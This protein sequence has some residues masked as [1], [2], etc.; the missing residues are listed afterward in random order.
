MMSRCCFVEGAFIPYI[1]NL[2]HPTPL[3]TYRE[4][5]SR[6]ICSKFRPLA[7]IYQALLWNEC[8]TVS[9]YSVWDDSHCEAVVKTFCRQKRIPREFGYICTVKQIDRL[10][11][12]SCKISVDHI[13]RLRGER[14][15]E[16]VSLTR[17]NYFYS[18]CWSSEPSGVLLGN[19]RIR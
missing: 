11:K 14:F 15:A 12:T 19:G 17:M 1:L 7:K 10:S 9:K 3:T 4:F 18:G 16:N 6:S 13:R 8:A 5:F 2:E